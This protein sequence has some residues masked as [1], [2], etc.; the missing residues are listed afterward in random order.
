MYLPIILGTAREGRQSEK[1][2]RFMLA[3][4]KNKGAE[5]EI[6]DVRDYRMEATDNTKKSEKAKMLAERMGKAY[7]LVMVSPEYNHGYPGELKMMLDLLYEEYRGKPALICG[8]SRGVFGGTRM[9]EQ[10]RLVCI[11]LG[12]IPVSDALYFS[13]VEEFDENGTNERYKK[14]AEKALG[15]L[16]SRSR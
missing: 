8:V 4:V 15:E 9:V 10:L 12:M 6:L 11:G 3:E 1:V 13:N 7:G 14:S 5:S 16:M 2:A